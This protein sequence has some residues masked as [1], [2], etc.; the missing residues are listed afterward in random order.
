MK[1]LLWQSPE[2]LLWLCP[3]GHSGLWSTS[4]SFFILPTSPSPS[5]FSAQL[6]LLVPPGK[7]KEIGPTFPNFPFKFPF[8]PQKFVKTLSAKD[9]TKLSGFQPYHSQIR[10]DQGWLH[11][12]N[13]WNTAKLFHSTKEHTM[14]VSFTR[15]IPSERDPGKKVMGWPAPSTCILAFGALS[16]KGSTQS[17][18]ARAGSR[19]WVRTGRAN[20]WIGLTSW[21]CVLAS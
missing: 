8:L 10:K 16:N 19:C 12:D 5:Q 4:S 21:C 11:S 7:R 1:T 14:T 3:S 9:D 6:S 15:I 2:C 20:F 17:G 18:W 13:V